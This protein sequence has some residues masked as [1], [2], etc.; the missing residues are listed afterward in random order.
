MD[1]S[2]PWVMGTTVL[3]ITT[4]LLA[5]GNVRERQAAHDALTLSFQDQQEAARLAADLNHCVEDKAYAD[6]L[7]VTRGDTHGQESTEETTQAQASRRQ[8]A[9]ARGAASVPPSS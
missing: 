1:S 3:L 6:Q 2:D 7:T 9:L 4:I 8:L 5:I